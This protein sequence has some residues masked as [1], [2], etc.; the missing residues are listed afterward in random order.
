MSAPGLHGI[1]DLTTILSGSWNSANTDN[2]TPTVTDNLTTPWKD[3]DMITVDTLF[4]KF[5]TD[6]PKTGLN[7]A[8]FFHPFTCTIE[9]LVPKIN[10]TAT[11]GAHFIKVVD[12]TV[13]LIKANAKYT[14]YAM[15]VVRGYGPPRYNKDKATF[16]CPID[17]DF[18][19]VMTS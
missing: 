18:L 12:E 13:R 4:I 8:E 6:A 9:V 19:K 1:T 17:V 16:V 5:D 10:A 7:A 2:K 3:M 15:M 14:G 11:G